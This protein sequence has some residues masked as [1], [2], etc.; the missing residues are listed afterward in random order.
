MTA[1]NVNFAHN[2]NFRVVIHNLKG[3]ELFCTSTNLP[4]VTSSNIMIN[5]P[6]KGMYVPGVGGLTK[7]QL[8]LDFIVDEDF[9]NY[10]QVLDW[11]YETSLPKKGV[12]GAAGYGT[13]NAI[14]RHLPYSDLT[15]YIL[16]NNMNEI[17][18]I[19]F[20]NTLPASLGSVSFD[21]GIDAPVPVKVNLS[22]DYDYF[23]KNGTRTFF[24]E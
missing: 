14:K 3:V 21:S 22:L 7:E 12:E 11:I 17:F 13:P 9:D 1:R 19:D 2:P 5:G 10:F 23:K 16:D 8:T 6:Q 20:V 18:A 15:L 4:S 24:E